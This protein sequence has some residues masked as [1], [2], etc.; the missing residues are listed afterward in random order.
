MKSEEQVEEQVPEFL[1][2]TG[3]RIDPQKQT[4]GKRRWVAP[5]KRR[6]IT[7]ST[8]SKSPHSGEVTMPGQTDGE[9]S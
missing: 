1:T 7:E 3:T 6:I 4:N 5:L 2:A 9:A 8:G